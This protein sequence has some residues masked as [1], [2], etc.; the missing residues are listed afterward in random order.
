MFHRLI[1]EIRDNLAGIRATFH[2]YAIPLFEQFP[3]PGQ[4]CTNKSPIE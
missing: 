3:V 4:G 2:V 1:M